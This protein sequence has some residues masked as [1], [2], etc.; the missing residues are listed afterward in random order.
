M[1]N[2]ACGCSQGGEEWVDGLGTRH[3]GGGRPRRPN[4]ID[5]N[6]GTG[7]DPGARE[8]TRAVGSNAG[9]GLTYNAAANNL[10]VKLSNHPDNLTTWDADHAIY[11]PGGQTA[12]AVVD[13]SADTPMMA[14]VV[15]GAQVRAVQVVYPANLPEP[16]NRQLRFEGPCQYTETVAATPGATIDWVA[17]DCDGDYTVTDV[18]TGESATVAIPTGQPAGTE[19]G[20]FR[21]GWWLVVSNRPVS[22]AGVEYTVETPEADDPEPATGTL[23]P[24]EQR[25]WRAGEDSTFTLTLTTEHAAGQ[26]VV[27]NAGDSVKT[28]GLLAAGALVQACARRVDALPSWIVGGSEGA[29]ANTTPW[30]LLRAYQRAVDRGLHAASVSVYGLRDHT[31]VIAPTNGFTPGWTFEP[32]PSALTDVTFADIGAP[33]WATI[34]TPVGLTEGDQSPWY[35]FAEQNQRGANTLEEVLQVAGGRLVLF[36][37]VTQLGS[38]EVERVIDAIARRCL[39]DSVVVYSSD[40]AQLAPVRDAGIA[41]GATVRA[42]TLAANTPEA[43]TEAGVEWVIATT[44]PSQDD[45]RVAWPDTTGYVGAGLQVLSNGLTTRYDAATAR[46]FQ[47]RGFLSSDPLY[48]AD[49]P[50]WLPADTHDDWYSWAM[51]QGQY[52]WRSAALGHFRTNEGDNRGG[53]IERDGNLGYRMPTDEAYIRSAVS[54]GWAAPLQDPENFLMVWNTLFDTAPSST[55]QFLAMV[56]CALD[57]RPALLRQGSG[58]D[59]DY[60]GYLCGY[61]LKWHWDGRMQLDRIDQGEFTELGAY[62]APAPTVQ[63]W[64]RWRVEV[65]PTEITFYD[66]ETPARRINVVDSRYRGHYQHLLKYQ[67]TGAF[68][69]AFSFNTRSFPG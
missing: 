20:E 29:G 17:P 58:T 25:Q 8:V 36:L 47:H 28:V 51:M 35:G 1:A 22:R 53:R 42:E 65:T 44:G 27:I 7:N 6:L 59:N 13:V 66:R 54:L 57:D 69:G 33:V 12:T 30:G 41:I 11:T 67:S 31:L 23:P 62:G 38:L 49:D 50:A 64:N 34:G 4:A 68:E 18:V 45:S 43:C 3:R 5:L 16:H 63:T 15:A 10:A 61:A 46:T 21:V 24:G 48:V 9:R 39:T 37:D 19:L 14:Q 52:P 32:P 40:L 2:G 60:P 55:S 56:I 26:Q